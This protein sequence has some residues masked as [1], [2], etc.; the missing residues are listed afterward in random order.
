MSKTVENQRE[1]VI[2]MVNAIN[3]L[4]DAMK[5]N[6]NWKKLFDDDDDDDDELFL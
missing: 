4:A 3:G 1:D 6:N 2:E 5:N